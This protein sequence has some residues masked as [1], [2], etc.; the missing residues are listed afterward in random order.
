MDLCGCPRAKISLPLCKY[1][2]PDTTYP[3]TDSRVDV[4]RCNIG[5]RP[6]GGPRGVTENGII[7]M[8]EAQDTHS[9]DRVA[10]R[11]SEARVG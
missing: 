11:P 9:L 8:L 3:G 2:E 1:K 4:R 7:A 6:L 10:E 5:R